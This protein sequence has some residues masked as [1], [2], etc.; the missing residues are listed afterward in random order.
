MS[1]IRAKK[2]KDVSVRRLGETALTFAAQAA[3]LD[4]DSANMLIFLLLKTGPGVDVNAVSDISKRA[5]LHWVAYHNKL[6]VVQDLVESGANLNAL[7]AQGMTPAILA[8]STGNLEMV[9]VLLSYPGADAMLEDN[10]KLTVH[11]HLVIAAQASMYGGPLG[12]SSHPAE[13]P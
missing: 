5:P 12:T 6:D 7:D 13:L 2:L 11:D 3:P 10:N 1:R 8:A 9:N 4:S